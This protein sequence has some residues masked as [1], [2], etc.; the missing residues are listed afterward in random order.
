MRIVAAA[1]QL[2]SADDKAA[3]IAEAE[4]AIARAGAAGARLVVLPELWTY[5]GRQEG[6]QRNAEPVP[7]PVTARLA[8]L[9]REHRLI[10][11]G[12]S[13]LE[14][15]PNAQGD[16][17][18]RNTT[19]VFDT[20]GTLAAT[21]RKIHLF[22]AAPGDRAAIYRESATTAPGDAVVSVTIDGMPLGL[23]ICYDLRFP[24]LFRALALAGAQVIV[25]PAAFTAETGRDHWEPLLRARAI[26]NGCYVVAAGQ[27][28]AHPPGR[29][30]WGHSMIVDPWG[31]ILADAGD[32]PGGMALAEL[33]LAR[34]AD[35]R[36]RL[37]SLANRRPDLYG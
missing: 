27:A 15:A 16:P 13:M 10:L 24:E 14:A 28:G 30:C 26:E 23:A 21:Y 4:A 22:D 8:A 37:P 34:V 25:L 6:N 1:M 12:G 7:G 2:N 17:R 18:P 31:D 3:N 9:A 32:A 36:R 11:H 29:R 5:L 20:E 35:V 33:D 19:V